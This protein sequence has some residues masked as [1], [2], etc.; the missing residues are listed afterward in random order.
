V[1]T[2]FSAAADSALAYGRALARSFTA[3][4][5]VVHVV[6]DL[7]GLAYGADGYVVTRPN[8]QRE[9]DDAARQQLDDLLIDNDEPPLPTRRLVICSNT[10]AAAIAE[11]AGREGID[12][13]VTGTHGRRAVA[14][15][16]LGSVAGRVVR[17]APC[18]VLTVRHPERE[19]V[20]P[21]A[22]VAVPK[23]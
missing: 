8:L 21:D 14:H 22:L 13:I 12:L 10:A 16:L 2:D 5:H 20:V 17:I 4:L 1:A 6:G 11:Y 7:S 15:W 19:F 18:A 9:I 23:A 3:T